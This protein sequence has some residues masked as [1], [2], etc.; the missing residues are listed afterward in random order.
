MTNIKQNVYLVSRL[1]SSIKN[2]VTL[3]TSNQMVKLSSLFFRLLA[4]DSTIHLELTLHFCHYLWIYAF[5]V[6]NVNVNFFCF[7]PCLFVQSMYL[8]QGQV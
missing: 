7:I 8:Q 3:S 5:P 2:S 6:S 4:A 1:I